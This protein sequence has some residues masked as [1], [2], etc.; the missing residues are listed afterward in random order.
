MMDPVTNK[1]GEFVFSSL[2]L[3]L[4]IVLILIFPKS[5]STVMSFLG[6]GS[7]ETVSSYLTRSSYRT[8]FR[9]IG[10]QFA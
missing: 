2:F 4:V 5:L 9:E 3:V 1:D 10:H 8:K 7:V 6:F